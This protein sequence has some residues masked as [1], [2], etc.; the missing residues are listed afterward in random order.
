MSILKYSQ[1]LETRNHKK[2][3]TDKIT[4]NKIK[5]NKKILGYFTVILW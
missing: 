2:I 3:E 1:F 4:N 5:K